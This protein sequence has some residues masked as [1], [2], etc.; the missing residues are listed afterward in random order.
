[1][2]DALHAEHADLPDDVGFDRLETAVEALVGSHDQLQQDHQ[3]LR[4][5]FA[6][7]N[8]RIRE[9]EGELLAANQRRQDAFKRIDELIAHL[10]QLDEQLG[11]TTE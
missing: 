3:R 11:E 6:Q 2:R 5:E 8:N 10:D 7:A 9:L 1:M 4:R